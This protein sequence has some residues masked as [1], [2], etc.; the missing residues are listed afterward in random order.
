MPTHDYFTPNHDARNEIAH[1]KLKH[2]KQNTATPKTRK[3]RIQSSK[4]VLKKDPYPFKEL[5]E[6]LFKLKLIFIQERYLFDK[7]EKKIL[8]CLRHK[9]SCHDQFYQATIQSNF[10]LA[11]LRII[12]MHI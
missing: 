12:S 10:K 4:E 5:K 2:S 3:T 11:P 1:T 9:S 7:L 6:A 8:S